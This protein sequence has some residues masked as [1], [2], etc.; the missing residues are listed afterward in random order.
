M[1]NLGMAF[2]LIVCMMASQAFAANDHA[3]ELTVGG[4]YAITTGVDGLTKKGGPAFGGEV[5]YR[6][7]DKL[8]LGVEGG[9]L[10]IGKAEE[11][12][13]AGG[14]TTTTTLKAYSIPILGVAKYEFWDRLYGMVGLG[15]AMVK[16]SA[17]VA[18]TPTPPAGTLELAQQLADAA[19]SGLSKTNFAAMLGVGYSLMLNDSISI[20]PR[21]K[22]YLIKI[23]G[24]TAKEIVPTLNV[25]FRL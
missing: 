8:S 12:E 20:D 16:Y 4:G 15:A 3:V 13:T 18:V 25:T 23:E 14:F 17:S 11:A 24:G 1:K 22:L 7:M 6:L 21:A 5:M 9:Y 2:L 19:A 10:Q